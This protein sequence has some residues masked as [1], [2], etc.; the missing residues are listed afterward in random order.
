M[1]TFK[2]STIVTL[3]LTVLSAVA[4]FAIDDV[5]PNMLNGPMKD[6]I[7]NNMDNYNAFLFGIFTGSLVSLIVAVVGY[8]TER[9]RL[10]AEI[11]NNARKLTI[12]FKLLLLDNIDFKDLTHEKL[13]K[14]I[15]D[16]QG[17]N[18]QVREW[19]TFHSSPYLM[20]IMQLDFMINH[21]EA[22]NLVKT[23]EKNIKILRSVVDGFMNAYLNKRLKDNYGDVD[24]EKLF[25][26]ITNQDKDKV[27]HTV[28]D[29]LDEIFNFLN[30]K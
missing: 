11:W 28:E 5:I 9:R 1:K 18:Q 22:A 7:L 26:V 10:I 23:L 14:I 4:I 6:H 8:A 29:L 21:G 30:K 27:L 16:Q 2:Y 17:F 15:E 20:N 13:S 24:I 12:D 19:L 25:A 3:I